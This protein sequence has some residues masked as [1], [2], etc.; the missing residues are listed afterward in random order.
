V[1]PDESVL[2]GV[3]NKGKGHFFSITERRYIGELSD[4]RSDIVDFC[5]RESDGCL[6]FY[7][8]DNTLWIVPLGPIRMCADARKLAIAVALVG[9]GVGVITPYERQ[10]DVMLAEAPVD[11]RAAA[12]EQWPWLIADVEIA[13]ASY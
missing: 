11:L 8:A 10:H 3:D 12:L 2:F 1:A 13:N 7:C 5:F 9:Q 4:V 6:A